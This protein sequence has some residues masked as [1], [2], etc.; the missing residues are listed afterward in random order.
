MQSVKP[1]GYYS[2]AVLA[3]FNFVNF[4]DRY[5]PTANKDLIKVSLNHQ[6]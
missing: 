4:L 3:L 6:F 1:R 5:I 2:L